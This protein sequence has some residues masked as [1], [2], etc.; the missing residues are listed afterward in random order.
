VEEEER[1]KAEAAKDREREADRTILMNFKSSQDQSDADEKIAEIDERLSRKSNEL[2]ELRKQMHRMGDFDAKEPLTGERKAHGSSP[3]PDGGVDDESGSKPMR[4]RGRLGLEWQREIAIR[5]RNENWN[6]RQAR[7]IAQKRLQF[8]VAKLQEERRLAEARSQRLAKMDMERVEQYKFRVKTD[9]LN[10]NRERH[11]ARKEERWL[12]MKLQH[13]ADIQL[14]FQEQKMDKETRIRD[15]REAWV[16]ELNRRLDEK[17]KLKDFIAQAQAAKDG[18][19]A[20]ARKVATQYELDKLERWRESRRVERDDVGQMQTC[21]IERFEHV[22]DE[23]EAKREAAIRKKEEA[24]NARAVARNAA[25]KARPKV[26]MG[27]KLKGT[28]EKAIVSGDISL[29]Y[30]SSVIEGEEGSESEEHIL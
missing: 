6:A 30:L 22:E 1:Q 23:R 8:D 9:L 4:Q 17:A 20:E 21:C 26:G 14:L 28:T 27:A 13:D 11:I 3:E 18:K 2:F 12:E 5:S 29:Y 7:L 16:G 15:A 19:V 24:R 10:K 25:T